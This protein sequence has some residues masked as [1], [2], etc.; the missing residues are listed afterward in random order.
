[1]AANDRGLALAALNLRKPSV[2]AHN[3]SLAVK[4]RTS[5]QAASAKPYVTCGEVLLR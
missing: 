3:I 5:T 1:M 2:Q 4:G